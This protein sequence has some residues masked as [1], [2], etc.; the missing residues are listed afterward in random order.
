[1]KKLLIL[2]ILVLAAG[3]GY[4]WY[5]NYGK[6]EERAAVTQAPLQLGDVVHSVQA[7]GTLEALRTVQVGSQ[8]SGTV[9]ELYADFNSIVREG[10]VI[11]ELDPSLLQVQVEVQ[12]ANIARQEGDIAQQEVQLEND[13]INMRRAEAQHERGLVSPQDLE[14]AQLQVKAREAQIESARKQLVQSRANLRQAELNVSYTIIRAPI[15][16]VVVN[17]LVDTGQTVQASMT[18]PQFF[19]I[20]TDLTTLRLSAGVDEADI[21]F[22]RRGMTV[23]FDVDSYQGQSFVGTVDAVRLNAQTQNNVVTYPVW[24]TVQNPELKLR[25]SMTANLRIIVD[26]ATNVLRVPN[27]ALRFRPTNDYYTWLGLT[28]PAPGGRGRGGAANAQKGGSAPQAD[29][30]E[31]PRAGT[32]RGA[33]AQERAPAKGRAAGAP[34]AEA[35]GQPAPAGLTAEGRGRRGG[36]GGFNPGDLTPEQMAEFQQRFGASGG[37]GGRQQAA[38]P[39]AVETAPLADRNAEKIDDLFSSVPKRIE[40]GQVWVYE[41]NA[42]DPARRLRQVNVRTGLNDGQFSEL[43]WNSEELTAGSMV[44]TGIVPPASALP[45]AGS[46]IFQQQR[47]G[48]G[49]GRGDGGRG[50]G[51]R[52]GR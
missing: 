18:T 47:G 13:V 3:G 11:A 27:Q 17:R 20:A 7:T 22:I 24:I 1:M 44:V 4:Y 34:T 15:D 6:S 52:G 19:T 16:G 21:G 9:K 51:G 28:P 42:T 48:F 14:A 38:A 31:A 50:G 46:N 35:D 8:V 5:T 10:Q 45:K 36:R 12:G 41:E 2:L 33:N 30:E 39:P 43:V 23:N 32:G 29:P 25:P 40:P 37:R 49:G 26:E